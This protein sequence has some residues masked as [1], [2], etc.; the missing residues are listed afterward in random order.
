MDQQLYTHGEWHVKD[1]RQ[2]EFI[3]AWKDLGAVFAALPDPPAGKGVLLQST[4]DATLFY[5]FGPWQTIEHVEA[6]REDPRAEEGIRRLLELCTAAS[7][8]TFRVV[9]ESP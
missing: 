8:G 2:D 1:G 9:A 4:S 6:M 3:A 5:S 7:P